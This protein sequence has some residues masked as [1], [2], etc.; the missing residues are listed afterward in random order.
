MA[1]DA[2]D[3]GVSTRRDY[4][5]YGGAV[6]A[7]G[8][9]AGCADQ[10]DVETADKQGSYEACIEPNGCYTFEEVPESIV[11]YEQ[12]VTD[13]LIA[14]DRTDGLVATAVPDRYPTQF[15][16]QLP[17][18][19]FDPGSV[20]DAVGVA[21]K[22]QFYNWDA[23]VH[24]LDH[25]NVMNRFD[26]D[27]GDIKEL[28]EAVG[29]FYGTY[30]RRPD[31]DGGVHYGLYE[32]FE[33]VAE[34]FQDR[35]NAEAL[36]ELHADLVDRI[37]SEL[38]PVSERPSVAYIN[39]DF[40]DTGKKVFVFEFGLRGTQYGAFRDLEI[41]KHSAFEGYHEDSDGIAFQ[42]D[43]ELLLEA[44]PEVII[45]HGGLGNIVD[46]DRDYELMAEPLTDDPVASEVTAVE[47]NRIYPIHNT[48]QG[49][50][51]RM[52]ITE[53]FAKVLYPDRFGEHP[54]AEPPYENLME[55]LPEE[56][57]LFDRQELADI[58]NGDS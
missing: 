52:F 16:D 57:Q 29:P 10:S 6:L 17:E 50:I 51:T 46:P 35:P 2:T 54:N 15:L 28:E 45:Y 36:S 32:G 1:D 27:T 11:T 49:P 33:K 58:I 20:E 18:V 7:G 24:L 44:D 55:P 3:D 31:Y 48:L 9:L 56:E 42:A 53:L 4:M 38:P 34:A 39:I 12:V 22:E 14:L 19:S 5:R 21:G 40:W 23:D 13:M 26:L 41:E 47:E 43:K 8:V 25:R 37:R 30:L